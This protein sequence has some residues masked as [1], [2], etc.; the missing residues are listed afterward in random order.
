MLF[1]S[2]VNAGDYEIVCVLTLENDNYEVICEN[3]VYTIEPLPVEVKWEGYDRLAYNSQAKNVTAA[4]TNVI[5]EDDVSVIVTGG[6][7]VDAGS[8]TAV[9]TGLQGEDAANYSVPDGLECNYMIDPAT[10]T[11]RAVDKTSVY[12]EPEEELTIEV[13]EGEIF[14]DELEIILSKPNN[15]NVGE[16]NIFCT[17]KYNPNYLVTVIPGGKYTITEREITI[18]WRDRKSTRLNSSHL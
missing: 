2:G 13:I 16:Y 3:G 14:N 6:D 5:G 12:G 17:T 4:V 15:K 9:V 1:R 11:I 7:A 18:N 8:H 10:P